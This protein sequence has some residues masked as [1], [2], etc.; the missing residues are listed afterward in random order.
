MSRSPA[1]P[2]RAMTADDIA[3]DGCATIHARGDQRQGRRLRR[4]RDPCRKRLPAA[5]IPVTHP[6]PARGCLWRQRGE[7]RPLRHG[8]VRGH[9]RRNSRAAA[10][11]FGYRRMRATTTRGTPTLPPHMAISRAGWTR[12]RPAYLHFADMDG[13]FSNSKLELDSSRAAPN[14]GGPLVANG[15][16]TIAQGAEL[17]AT[18]EAQAITRSAGRFLR[19]SRPRRPDRPFGRDRRAA[20]RGAGTRRER[21]AT[22]TTPFSRERFPARRD[23]DAPG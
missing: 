20:A 9:R 15:G 12:R 18:G 14:Y 17:L 8:R 4:R 3:Q 19:Q 21:S 1:T 7:P 11:A 6:Q 13:W 2:S 10:S 5:S 22:P 16:L 23:E